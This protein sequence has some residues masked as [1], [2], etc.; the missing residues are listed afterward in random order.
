MRMK[1]SALALFAALAGAIVSLPAYAETLGPISDETPPAVC[2]PGSFVQSL[3]CTGE[4]CDNVSITC[5]SRPGTA[6]GRGMWTKWFSEEQGGRG[7]CPAKHF[8]AGLACQKGWC[9]NV[10]LYCVEIP[11]ASAGACTD[12]RQTGAGNQSRVTVLDSPAFD[13]AGQKFL[14]S[15]VNCKGGWCGSLGLC[16]RE[17]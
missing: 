3:T 6:L 14:A 2:D 13:K 8:V 5:Q 4:R 17:Q 11:G 16:V 15:G 10:S 12:T 9:D 1:F 7:S